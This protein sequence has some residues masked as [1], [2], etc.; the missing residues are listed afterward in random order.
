MPTKLMLIIS[1]NLLLVT[2]A[3]AQQIRGCS[4]TLVLQENSAVAELHAPVSQDD[5]MLPQ[6]CVDV[7]FS[8]TSAEVLGK[9]VPTRL[10]LVVATLDVGATLAKLAQHDL[11]N[12]VISFTSVGLQTEILVQRKN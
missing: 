1:M 5:V 2:V 10:K 7:Y 6:D 3:H 11:S 12:S 4:A 9:I 8:G